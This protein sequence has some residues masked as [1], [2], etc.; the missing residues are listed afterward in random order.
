MPKCYSEQEREYIRSRL[1][2]E[3]TKCLAQYGIRRT[4]VDEIVKR[5]KIP[6]GTFYLFYPSKETLLF[7]VI[8]DQ[9]QKVDEMI[10]REMRAVDPANVSVE[11]I[12]DILFRFY[13]LPA[14]MPVLKVIDSDAIMLLAHKLPRGVLEEHFEHDDTMLARVFSHLPVKQGIDVK[15]FAS[16]FQSLYFSTLHREEIG[17]ENFDEG[18]RLLI[19]GLVSQ[20][21]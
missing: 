20:L 17:K 9:H 12:T 21:L 14:E 11:Q 18:L 13:R 8:L 4:T 2:E 5:V 7:E 6:K 3:A 15:A 10:Y 16:A 1:K 19:R